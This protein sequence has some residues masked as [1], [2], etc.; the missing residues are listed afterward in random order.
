MQKVIRDGK[1]AVV[2]G[3]GWFTSHG[4]EELLYHPKIVEL[5]EQNKRSMIT[6][7]LVA[8]ILNIDEKY[9][10]CLVSAIDLDIDWIN[11]GTTFTVQCRDGDEF[12]VV[13]DELYW[14]T[15]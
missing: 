2:Y 14:L 13:Y 5:I 4:Y 1:V 10:P 15:A 7:S 11:Q 12:I 3:F 8:E 9:C 6:K